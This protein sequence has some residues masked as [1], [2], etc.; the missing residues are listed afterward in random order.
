M[1]KDDYIGFRIEADVKKMLYEK[2]MEKN[3]G[4]SE[5]VRWLILQFLQSN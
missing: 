1:L 3:K 2:C 4:L 5:C